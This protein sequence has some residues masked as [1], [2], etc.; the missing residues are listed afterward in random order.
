DGIRDFH[1]TGVQTCALPILNGA[2]KTTLT[3]AVTGMLSFHGGSVVSGDIRWKGR[4]I[5]GLNPRR[6]VRAGISQVLEGR[7][8][9]AELTVDQIG[10]ASCRGRGEIPGVVGH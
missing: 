8:I 1:V 10:R 7:R 3:R 5:V 2:G 6:I 9:F 4:S